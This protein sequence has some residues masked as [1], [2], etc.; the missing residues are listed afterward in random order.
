M[1][2]SMFD[3][4]PPTHDENGEKIEILIE[5]ECHH[6]AASSAIFVMDKINPRFRLGLSG[7]PFRTDRVK[8]CF[9]KTIRDCGIRQLVEMGYLSRYHKYVIPE[10]TPAT[11]ATRYLAEPERWGKSAF[12]WRT[13]EDARECHR[14]LVAGGCNAGL[15]L[16]TQ[17]FEERENTL[18]LF[19]SNAGLD[20]IVNLFILTEGWDMPG[21]QTAWVRDSSRGPTT[22]MA[23]R[24][25]RKH[26]DLP[27]KQIVQSQNT[28]YPVDKIVSPDMGY[29]WTE[30]EWR[31]VKA[32]DSVERVA[33]ETMMYIAH[34]TS[35]VPEFIT[36]K[37]AQARPRRR[38]R[39]GTPRRIR[40]I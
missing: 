14:L 22:Q 4:E 35:T 25:F 33:A 37:L 6:S 7:T 21:L 18:D 13:E 27:I 9:Q 34:S 31:S 32:D 40:E 3:K 5:D 11:V 39:G 12:Y 30:N 19:E 20:A 26:P 29:V 1:P 10:W 8:L 16:G 36:K 2:I 38:R 23:G 15:V 17:S 28:H 24:V